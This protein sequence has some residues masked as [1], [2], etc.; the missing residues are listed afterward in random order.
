MALSSIPD[1]EVTANSTVTITLFDSL[2]DSTDGDTISVSLALTFGTVVDN[3][4][5][6]HL[7][8]TF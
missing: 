3:G 6:D 8:T 4:D 2:V 1:P 5:H 7:H